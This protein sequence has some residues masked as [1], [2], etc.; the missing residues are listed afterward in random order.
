MQEIFDLKLDLSSLDEFQWD[1]DEVTIGEKT[2]NDVSGKKDFE[3]E[4]KSTAE[5]FIRELVQNTLDAKAPSNNQVKILN[6]E[7]LDFSQSYTKDIYTRFVNG[8][9][10]KWLD[11]SKSI[12][13][14]YKLCF[15][16]LV[17]SDFNTTGLSGDLNDPNSNWN[18]YITRVGN[19]ELS[20]DGSLGSAGIGKIATWS[21]SRLRMVFIRTMI[22]DPCSETRFIGRCL[23]RGNTEISVLCNLVSSGSRKS[24]FRS[25]LL[26]TP[27]PSKSSVSM[28]QSPSSSIPLSAY[29]KEY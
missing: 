13:P 4:G 25:P 23:R 3:K 7:L 10:L 14:E 24:T 2:I 8:K 22:D 17:A 15:K 5:T 16:A 6:L 29:P 27:F 26:G 28:F 21:C 12:E 18:K 20:K 1:A 19:P 11:L 9:I